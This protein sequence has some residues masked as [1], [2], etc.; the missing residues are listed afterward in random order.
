M[1]ESEQK[2][3]DSMLVKQ[4]VSVRLPLCALSLGGFD[5]CVSVR[6]VFA[7]RYTG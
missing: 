7:H 1:Y 4:A 3:K 6:D 2:S 5:G